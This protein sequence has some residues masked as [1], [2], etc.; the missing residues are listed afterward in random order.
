MKPDKL[1]AAQRRAIMDDLLGRFVW[2]V[3]E[4]YMHEAFEVVTDAARRKHVVL[5]PR[6]SARAEPPFGRWLHEMAH[7]LLAESVHPQFR[8]PFFSK[9]TAAPVRATYTPLFEAALDWYVQALLM[10]VAPGPQG[11]DLDERFRMSA[12]MLRQGHALPS[13]E[14]VADAGLALASFKR[15]RGL[16]IDTQGKL[17]LVVRAFGRAAPEKPTL[18]GLQSLSRG[19][20]EAFG[21]HT[22]RLV[23]ER[24]FERW[25][26]EALK[27]TG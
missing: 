22:A 19:L 7:A 16:E 20:M 2:P 13:V 11:A 25:R 9:E 23:C 8:K 6:E 1:T 12:H 21:L 15:W 5:W 18:F 14:F 3:E 10:D 26:V 17:N 4:E 24:G 27:P